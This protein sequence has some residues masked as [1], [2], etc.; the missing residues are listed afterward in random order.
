MSEC[1]V[2][3]KILGVKFEQSARVYSTDGKAPTLLTG[4][5]SDKIPKIPTGVKCQKSEI[6][7]AAL[8]GGGNSPPG[9]RQEWDNVYESK[10]EYRKLTVTECERLQTVPDGY[11]SSVSKSQAYKMLGNGWTVDVIAHIFGYLKKG[12]V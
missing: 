7:R 8:E 11:T 12:E 5:S 3:G 1:I 9:S 6:N 10:V 4:S 2:A